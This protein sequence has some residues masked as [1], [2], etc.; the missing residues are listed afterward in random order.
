MPMG[1]HSASPESKLMCSISPLFQLIPGY[2][3][4]GAFHKWWKKRSK[5]ELIETTFSCC[6]NSLLCIITNMQ[7]HWYEL[8]RKSYYIYFTHLWFQIGLHHLFKSDWVTFYTHRSQVSRV[9]LWASLSVCLREICVWVSRKMRIIWSEHLNDKAT[10][11]S[12]VRQ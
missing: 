2:A 6:V 8:A 4:P 7:N 12:M 10:S 9:W 11:K 3:V 1:I 5:K